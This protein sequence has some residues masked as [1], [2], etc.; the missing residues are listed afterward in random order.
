MDFFLDSSVIIVLKET[1]ESCTIPSI[2]E[3]ALMLRM[4]QTAPA[5]GAQTFARAQ[6]Y[7]PAAL[8]PLVLADLYLEQTVTSCA[9]DSMNE[10]KG[11]GS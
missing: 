3:F 6:C 8:F 5:G 7:I 11:N 9:F 10:S 1:E 2:R 4:L